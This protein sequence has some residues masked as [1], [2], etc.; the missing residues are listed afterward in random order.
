MLIHEPKMAQVDPIYLIIAEVGGRS[1]EIKEPRPGVYEIGHFGGSHMLRGYEMYPKVSVG[2]YGVC[3]NI[4]QLLEACPELEAP[5]REFVVT[6]TR[7][8]K[9]EQQE[10]GGWRWHKWGSYIGKQNPS[11]EYIHDE[12]EI[13]QVFCYHIYE[14]MKG[15]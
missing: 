5:S 3:D 8:V 1:L 7:I 12:P 14:K 2:P 6:L 13:E 4:E 9:A 15:V 11:C 10:S